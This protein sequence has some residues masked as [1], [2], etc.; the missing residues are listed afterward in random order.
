MSVKLPYDVKWEEEA[1]IMQGSREWRAFIQVECTKVDDGPREL[2]MKLDNFA[3]YEKHPKDGDALV[4]LFY[5]KRKTAGSNWWDIEVTWSTDV[6]V[7]ANPIS[8]P[9]EWTLDSEIR[10]IPAVFDC[11]GNLLLNTAGALL[12][13]PPAGRK[14]V[15]E[16]LSFTKNV[17]LRL[18]DWVRTHPGTVNNDDVTIRGQSYPPGTLWFASRQVGKEQNVPG[19]TDS[20]STLRGTPYTTVTGTLMYREDGWIEYYPNRGWYQL[21]PVNKSLKT[22]KNAEI[23]GG[24]RTL[25]QMRAQFRKTA[26]YQP[27][28][29]LFGQFGDKVQEPAFLDAN[30]AMIQ[31]P[32]FD[33]IILL[34]YDGY[35]KTAFNQ[36]P[37]R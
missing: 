32:T 12:T 17:S 10:E 8:M 11:N 37:V 21:V 14:I 3:P 2:I 22:A 16:T 23:Q 24:K 27:W 35:K 6:D 5:P 28:P 29:C 33:N 7:T 30:G 31:Q 20:I 18:P 36:L 15:D 4:N 26:D 13:D 34:S 25:Q 1:R 19:A 9:A